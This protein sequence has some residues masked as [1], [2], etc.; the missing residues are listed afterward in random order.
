MELKRLRTNGVMT[1]KK[2]RNVT[3]RMKKNMFH[4]SKHCDDKNVQ[5]KH[6]QLLK[7]DNFFSSKIE[8]FIFFFFSFFTC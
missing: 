1:N 8:N 2:R 3:E 7:Q 4:G 6:Q 5:N